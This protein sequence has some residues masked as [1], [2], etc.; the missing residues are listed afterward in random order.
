VRSRPG[1]SAT[2]PAA[3]SAPS[4]DRAEEAAAEPAWRESGAVA[5]VWV[6]GQ[7]RLVEMETVTRVVED[8]APGDDDPADD[9]ADGEGAG[10]GG[11]GRG[12]APSVRDILKSEAEREARLRRA[13][14]SPVETQAEMS[15][16]V[17]PEVSG[18]VRRLPVMQDDADSPDT[19]VSGAATMSRRDLLPNIEEIN[20]TLRARPPYGPT[21]D[22]AEP[23]AP[24]SEVLRRRGVRIG[25][26]G[27]LAVVAL[28]VGIYVNAPV[29][30]DR[31]P[32]AAPALARLTG[33]IDVAR[34]WLD[35]LA[36]GLAEDGQT[37]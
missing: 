3:D 6:P 5:E 1:E 34:L 17:G 22:D 18:R 10:A 31:L 36:R 20:S 16:D 15:L 7:G 32:Q 23:A 35:D 24:S 21:T 14:A 2:A 26:F 30:A 13:E 29:I 4:P 37:P 9:R 12:L 11:S 8:N 25:F 19:E 33:N 27:T 28:V